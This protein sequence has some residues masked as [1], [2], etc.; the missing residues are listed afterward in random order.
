MAQKEGLG[1]GI[2][3]PIKLDDFWDFL[4]NAKFEVD[5]ILK[6]RP[7]EMRDW[8]SLFVCD[9]WLISGDITG[10]DKHQ[11][12]NYVT[13]LTKEFWNNQLEKI[14]KYKKEAKKWKKN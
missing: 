11:K 13:K 3:M 10:M 8:M 1:R 14:K 12:E 2:L 6:M 9:Y 7:E 4:G 5:D